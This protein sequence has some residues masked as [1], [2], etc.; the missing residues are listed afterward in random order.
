MFGTGVLYLIFDKRVTSSGGSDHVSKDALTWSR[1][2]IGA[3]VGLILVTMIV[4]R[5]SIRSLQA[6]QGLPIGNQVVGWLVLG[7][8]T[9]S[10]QSLD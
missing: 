9:T 10:T 8:S 1:I 2:I 6:K 7:R 3:Q 4:T 5:S